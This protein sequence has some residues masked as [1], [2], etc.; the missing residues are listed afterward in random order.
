MD[1]EA[2]VITSL[3]IHSFREYVTANSSSDDKLVEIDVNQN[4]ICS[5]SNATY[6]K[7]DTVASW[8]SDMKYANHAGTIVTFL[9]NQTHAE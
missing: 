4:T 8:S 9:M 3:S 5:L 7:T 2:L 6:T 1:T